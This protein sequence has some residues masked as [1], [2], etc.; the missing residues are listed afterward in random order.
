MVLVNDDHVEESTDM[1]P[2]NVKKINDLV[3]GRTINR[4]EL[5]EESACLSI[6][7]DDEGKES[8]L[9]SLD[10]LYRKEIDIDD[11]RFG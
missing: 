10:H 6:Y 1:N 5:T 2:E 7:L 4:L 9:I 3:A 11:G 8:I